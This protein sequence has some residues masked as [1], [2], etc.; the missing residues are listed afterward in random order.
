MKQILMCIF[1]SVLVLPFFKVN[2]QQKNIEKASFRSNI[3]SDIQKTI[4]ENI[5]FIAA[6]LPHLREPDV[7]NN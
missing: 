2:A 4:P 7:R 5:D 1:L 6:K 3:R